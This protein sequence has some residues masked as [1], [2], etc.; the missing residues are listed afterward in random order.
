MNEKRILVVDDD[1]FIL[2]FLEHTLKKFEPNFDV[3]TVVSGSEALE[4]LQMA[5]FDL[6][7]TDYL[8][9]GISG[10]D[11]ANA[12][13]H[14]TPETA[15]VLMTAYANDQLHHTIEL[16]SVD[17]YIRKPINLSQVRKVVTQT[18]GGID[19]QVSSHPDQENLDQEI[20]KYLQTLHLNAG[21]R[22][23][24]LLSANGEAMQTVGQVSTAEASDIAKLVAAHCLA[25]QKLADLL[26]RKS[27]YRSSS[28]EEED[29]YIYTYNV[30][31]RFLLA[32]IFGKETRPGVVWIYTK[33]AAE[34]LRPLVEQLSDA[35]LMIDM[36]LTLSLNGNGLV[37]KT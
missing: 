29:Y 16:L 34:G 21:A 23:V 18:I 33:Q 31:D 32:V 4:Q 7:I 35:T 1:K 28:F 2:T 30:D 20:H 11:L 25:A 22:F 6:V 9:P 8:M 36:A 14:M 5:R 24:V 12:I 19:Q 26:K 27:H 10:V 15:V 13:R 17:G 37:A 3:T